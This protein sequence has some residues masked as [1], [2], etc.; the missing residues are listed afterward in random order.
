MI[1]CSGLAHVCR[2]HKLGLR[3]HQFRHRQCL[4]VL[5]WCNHWPTFLRN[6]STPP[7]PQVRANDIVR[8]DICAA[9]ISHR[10]RPQCILSDCRSTPLCQHRNGF[11]LRR[12]L[13]S[14]PWLGAPSIHSSC[15]MHSRAT[16]YSTCMPLRPLPPR[17]VLQHPSARHLTWRPVYNLQQCITTCRSSTC[18]TSSLTLHT[19]SS[20]TLLPPPPPL[21]LPPPPQRQQWQHLHCTHHEHHC[22][23]IIIG[24]LALAI[25]TKATCS[26]RIAREC[27]AFIEV[28]SAAAALVPRST[29]RRRYR[30]RNRCSRLRSCH[31]SHTSHTNPRHLRWYCLPHHS[32]SSCITASIIIINNHNSHNNNPTTATT[33]CITFTTII[34]SWQPRS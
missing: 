28:T 6:R 32:T 29:S 15:R 10:S 27:V 24:P 31:T 21:A 16:R 25:D 34:T 13:C 2:L 8:A 14:Q 12:A 9:L 23:I 4:P 18:H 30:Y 22:H 11:R 7:R 19:R 3:R 33:I 1:T 17:L 20:P 5:R 26:P